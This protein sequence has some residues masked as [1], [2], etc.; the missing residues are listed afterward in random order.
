M[1]ESN[2]S[3]NNASYKKTVWF[4]YGSDFLVVAINEAFFWFMESLHSVE[5][6]QEHH[7]MII[8][9]SLL[10]VGFLL[11]MTGVSIHAR[12]DE[13]LKVVRKSKEWAVMDASIIVG[14]LLFLVSGIWSTLSMFYKWTDNI[15]YS[16]QIS[17]FLSGVVYMFIV[18]LAS[19]KAMKYL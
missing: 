2:A 9:T 16:F 14:E 11:H 3:V 1:N 8:S 10:M 6:S 5:K 17:L 19:R 12:T 4:L 15:S 18:V 13:K 7:N